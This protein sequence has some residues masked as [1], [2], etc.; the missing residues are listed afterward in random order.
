M[1]KSD[2][3]L[4]V[5]IILPTYNE[6]ENLP[7]IIPKICEVVGAA[8]IRFEVMV[9]DD[10]S[11]DGTADA[12]RALAE[13]Y[14]V[15]TI[16]RTEERGL[17]TAVMEG[18]KQSTADVCVVM[19]ADGSH[20]IERLPEM[21]QP[22]LQGLTP[23]TVG[24]RNVPGGEIGQWPWYRQL[25]SKTAGLMTFGLTRMTDP[26]SGFMAVR[27]AALEG[28]ELNP[29]GWKIVLEVAVKLRAR[30]VEVPI[31]FEDRVHGKSKMNPREQWN[32]IRHL[33]RLHEYRRPKLMQYFQFCT[34]GVVG[35]FVDL[36]TVVAM[37]EL[38][39]LDTRICALG[40]FMVA[41]TSNYFMN[42]YWT[43]RAVPQQSLMRGYF[44]F[45][46]VCVFGLL[47]RMGV[48]QLMMS[49]GFDDGNWLHGE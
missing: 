6:V 28:V 17:A 22:V 10:N 27:R 45:V 44:L 37:K 11:P 39:G 40:G 36:A 33:H 25:I 30:P 24:S 29:V 20:P 2:D 35:L 42:R 13:R 7:V 3:N 18:F 32:F 8:D 34:V 16:V 23:I 43:F 12:A 4:E 48:V 26:T 5:S 47:G 15:R 21:I 49:L 41:V 31:R 14:P 9:V 46:L 1:D 38:L 19:D